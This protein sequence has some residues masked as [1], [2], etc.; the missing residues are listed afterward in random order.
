MKQPIDVTGFFLSTISASCVVFSLS[1]ISPPA[2]P[3]IIGAIMIAMGIAA[4]LLYVRQARTTR[5]PL[6]ELK[7]F[8]N[9]FFCTAIFGDSLFRVKVGA[10]PFLL[11]LLFQLGFGLSPLQSGMITFS[12]LT[13]GVVSLF[14]AFMYARM[15]R[16]AGNTIISRHCLARETA[17]EL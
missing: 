12:F 11:P 6:F 4:G 15:T 7:L 2:L 9:P 8:S 5:Y 13:V 14:S 3:P 1:V 17:D 16:D 10:A